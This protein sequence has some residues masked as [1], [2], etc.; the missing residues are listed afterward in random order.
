MLRSLHIFDLA[1]I[2][3]AHIPFEDGLTV[4][5]G[6]TGGGKSL[7]VTALAWLRGERTQASLVR[8][9]AREARVDGEFELGDGPRS[10]AVSALAAELAGQP[11]EDGMLLLSRIV[12]AGGRSRARLN[13]R[14]ITL[15]ALRRLGAMLLEIHGQGESRALMR[16]EIQ[17]ETLDAF[18]G[19]TALRERFAS[20]LAGA[21]SAREAAAAAEEV[22]RSRRA[23]VA[24]LAGLVEEME[25]LGL[26]AGERER[27]EAEHTVLSGQDRL[28]E[29]VREA[30]ACLQEQDGSARELLARAGRALAAAAGIDREL[31]PAVEA[32]A[33]AE[34]LAG[35]ACR[36]LLSSLGRL[37]VEPGRLEFV[38]DRLAE[39]RRALARHGPEEADFLAALERAR[40]ELAALQAAEDEPQRARAELAERLAELERLGAELA[41]ARRTASAGFR[42]AIQAD[43]RDL[44]MPA[45]RLRVV[46]EEPLTGLELL[47]HATALGP[48]ACRLEVRTNAGEPFHRLEE[49]ASGGELAR[50]VLAVKKCL[51][52]RD[53]VP[54]LVLDEIDAEIGGR[55]GLAVGRKLREVARHHQVLTVTH[56]PQ[57]AAFADAHLQVRKVGARGRTTVRV[58]RLLTEE[59]ERELAAMALGDA[60]DAQALAEARRLRERARGERGA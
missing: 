15:Q 40:E 52:D 34:G 26:E 58:R 59:V 37:D 29:L 23:R 5:S 49:T 55:L 16:P 12:D 36:E 19:T 17:V 21:R 39:L 24:E 53:R 20:A 30:L 1:L 4:L 2:D 25:A 48:A 41:G 22:E 8:R 11:V 50:L 3:K 35:E 32:L 9:G 45:A 44:G 54:L 60:A 7:V 51:A 28:R 56:L 10:A 14:P 47:D 13:D 46:Q 33:E 38:E 31:A 27:L 18:A 6:E 43:L 57:V 42:A